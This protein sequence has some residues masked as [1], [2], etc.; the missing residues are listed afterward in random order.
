[1]S[2]NTLFAEIGLSGDGGNTRPYILFSMASIK[3]SVNGISVGI[4]FLK[5]MMDRGFAHSID[6]NTQSTGTEKIEILRLNRT[7]NLKLRNY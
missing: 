2:F 3:D 5:M 6:Q 1:M 7:S 4:Y